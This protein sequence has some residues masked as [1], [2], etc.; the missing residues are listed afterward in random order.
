[1]IL[2][3]AASA[4]KTLMAL[5]DKAENASYGM[6]VHVTFPGRPF[7]T[8]PIELHCHQRAMAQ[9]G[10]EQASGGGAHSQPSWRSTL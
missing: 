6:V 5:P 8:S 7:R 2:A 10:E 1:M 3:S 9:A 4:L